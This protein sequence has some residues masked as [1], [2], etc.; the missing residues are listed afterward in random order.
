[1]VGYEC[2]RGSLK[3]RGIELTSDDQIALRE[4]LRGMI[5]MAEGLETVP[6]LLVAIA[7]LKLLYSSDILNVYDVIRL[8]YRFTEV[9]EARVRESQLRQL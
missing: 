8:M 6:S 1:L 7:G 2:G 4:K 3:T 9:L 5:E